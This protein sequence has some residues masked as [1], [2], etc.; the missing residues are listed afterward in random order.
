MHEN[1][2][3]DAYHRRA[4]PLRSID[5]IASTITYYRRGPFLYKFSGV[6]YD[7][8]GELRELSL[9]EEGED[10][11]PADSNEHRE[12][13]SDFDIFRADAGSEYRAKMVSVAQPRAEVVRVRTGLFRGCLRIDG[14][15]VL[16]S[17]SMRSPQNEGT[18]RYVDWY[19][20][21]FG[22]VKSEVHAKER[23]RPVTTLEIVSFRD[24]RGHD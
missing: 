10:V 6:N 19:A 16:A 22:L 14:E 17:R 3:V 4:G 12:W 2:L 23:A 11:P 9:G 13:E 21:G 8:G 24:G 20:P 1:R 5:P 15:S 7:V 18:F